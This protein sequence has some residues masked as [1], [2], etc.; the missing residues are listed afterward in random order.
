KISLNPYYNKNSLIAISI[1]AFI[2]GGALGG[3]LWHFGGVYLG[4]PVWTP[5]NLEQFSS[6]DELKAFLNTSDKAFPPY[7]ANLLRNWAATLEAGDASQGG[8]EYSTTN[9]QVEGVDEADIVKTDGEFLYLI[10]EQNLYIIR[11]YPPSEAQIL[12]K[13][14]FNET[15]KG[16]FVNDEK[17]VIFQGGFDPYGVIRWERFALSSFD[18]MEKTSIRIYDI[19]NR[20]S[21][22]QVSRIVMDGYYFN[23]R[24]IGDNLYIIINKPAYLNNSEV[25]LPV[26]EKDNS[27]IEILATDIYYN[28]ITDYYYYFTNILALNLRDLELELI[29]ETFLL[30]A[31]SEI[32][33]SQK[34]MYLTSPENFGITHIYKINIED[35][36]IN[37]VAYGNVT[38]F[39]LNQFSMDEY[40]DHF[41]VATTKQ[42][43]SLSKNNVY[44]LNASLHMVG[45]LEDLAPGEDIHSARFMGDKCYL[46]TFKKIDPLFVIDLQDPENP[47]VLGKLKIPGYSDY[48]HPYDETHLIGVGKETVEAEIGDFAWYQG[49]KISFFDVSN[50][51]DPNVIDQTE[52]GDRGTDT[53][54][55]RDHK[56]FLFSKPQNLLVLPILLA[57]ID[58]N[59][60]PD[61]I[62]PNAY[63]E[64]VWQG[65][66]IFKITLEGGIEYA[67]RITHMENS[68]DLLKSG[69]YFSSLYEVKRA[70]YINRVLYTISD[71]KIKL[72]NLDTL[73]EIIEINLY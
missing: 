7:Y 2:I 48:L 52:I 8:T 1:I 11:A 38:G 46:V 49:V 66:Y 40:E 56:A 28:N 17:L 65:A 16:M 64:Y 19:S 27:S 31:T 36:A 41:R 54:V 10:S 37:Y 60:Y 18:E 55:L 47:Q 72:N 15:I 14:E 69:Y 42:D 33:V 53:P 25:E 63:G 32:Y 58:P 35:R 29:H 43:G 22:L 3:V 20:S 61:G 62:P 9:I 4:L 39:I 71:K 57:E 13:L 73:E 50:V 34:N 30:G 26:I 44:I 59:D 68:T 45:R 51:S 24:M 23:S 5:S 6:Y 12:S 70:L 21:P 67:G